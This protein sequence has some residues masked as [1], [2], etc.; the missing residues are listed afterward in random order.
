MKWDIV[1]SGAYNDD[2][3]LFFPEVLSQSKLDELRRSQGVYKFS[4][5][6]LNITVPDEDQDFKQGWIKYYDFLPPVYYTFIFIDPAI[7]LNDGADYTASVV[8]RVDP[9]KNWYVTMARRQRITAT[10]TLSWIFKLYDDLKPQ[11]VGIEEV[12]YQSALKQFIAEEMLRRNKI[13]PLKGI[14]RASFTTDGGLK[15]D[16][17]KGARIRSLIPRFEFG[18][19]FL[20]QGLD[21][22]LLEYKSFPRG[23]HDDLLDALSSIEDIVFYP[24]KPKEVQVVRHPND[25]GYESAFIRSLTQKAR[26]Q[27]ED[28]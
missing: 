23:A 25:P 26:S 8:V 21:D 27:T 4:N 12:A 22:L 15:S 5:N 7:S 19:I 24:D 1:Y 16:N 20:S 14:K 2:L 18:K 9:D 10:E 11:A 3:S 13:I 17:S 6:Y 28:Y